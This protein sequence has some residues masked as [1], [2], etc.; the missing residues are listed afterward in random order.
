MAA[1]FDVVALEELESMDGSG[2]CSWYLARKGLKLDSFGMNF[3]DIGADGAIPAH[4]E[5]D[6]GQEE[7]FIVLEGDAVAELDGADHAA[8]A[9]SLIRVGPEVR[10]RIRNDGDARARVLIV[11]APV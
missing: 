8:P 3:V 10:R 11:S 4:D 1:D 2:D 5:V 7:V 9:G 6:R